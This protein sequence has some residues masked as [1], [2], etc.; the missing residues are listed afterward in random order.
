MSWLDVYA[1]V[2]IAL[3]LTGLAATFSRWTG[4]LRRSQPRPEASPG[5]SVVVRASLSA[6]GDVMFRPWRHFSLRANPVWTIGCAVYHVAIATVL[7]TYAVSLCLLVVRFASGTPVPDAL[8][9]VCTPSALR[10]SNLLGLIF[11]NTEPVPARFLFGRVD[12][13]VI[14][15]TSVDVGLAEL[16]NLCLLATLLLG[17]MGA[18][19]HDLDPAARSVRLA[20]RRSLERGLVRSVIFLIIQSEIITRLHIWPAALYGHVFLGATLLAIAPYCYVAHV[21]YA[22][23]VLAHAW[24]RRRTGAVA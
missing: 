5:P 23:L 18:V 2:A 16:G 12:S 20:G 17:R 9:G 22:P 24:Q 10:P 15:A 1:S 14:A 19:L 3:L 13:A 4:L 6:L 7:A 11:A 8:S 21:F